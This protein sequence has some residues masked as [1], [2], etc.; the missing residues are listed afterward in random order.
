MELK[1]ILGWIILT[2]IFIGCFFAQTFIYM[3]EYGL[4]FLYGSGLTIIMWLFIAVVTVLVHIVMDW[5]LE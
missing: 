1:K 2:V 4:S 5:L 3:D